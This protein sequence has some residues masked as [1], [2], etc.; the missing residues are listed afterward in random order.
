[1]YTE[2]KLLVKVTFF[3]KVT[4]VNVTI[5]DPPLPTGPCENMTT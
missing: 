5:Y 2:V 1:M 3:Q 4:R